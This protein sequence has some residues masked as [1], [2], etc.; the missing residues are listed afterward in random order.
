MCRLFNAYSTGVDCITK[1]FLEKKK[2]YF[3]S[4]TQF[5]VTILGIIGHWIV[6]RTPEFPRK[7]GL[8]DIIMLVTRISLH[9]YQVSMF[10]DRRLLATT[11]SSAHLLSIPLAVTVS[12]FIFVGLQNLTILWRHEFVDKRVYTIYMYYY[13]VNEN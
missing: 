5:N 10:I 8:S 11:V 4:M 13:H 2:T 1:L 7:L 3:T 6:M 9:L 12:S